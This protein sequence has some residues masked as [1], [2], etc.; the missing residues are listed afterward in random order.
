RQRHGMRLVA[1]SV[2]Q[3]APHATKEGRR[4]SPP[5]FIHSSLV[6]NVVRRSGHCAVGGE[7]LPLARTGRPRQLHNCVATHAERGRFTGA[8]AT[9][10][11]TYT[12]RSSRAATSGRF[13]LRS[14][15][16][17]PASSRADATSGSL[18]RVDRQPPV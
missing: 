10:A 5:L 6:V 3:P 17:R 11:G 4:P 9:R 2:H 8:V 18:A 13:W 12:K 14:T 15:P 7:T 1:R 16:I